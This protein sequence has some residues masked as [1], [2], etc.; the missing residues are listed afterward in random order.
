MKTKQ[1]LAILLVPAAA[2]LGGCGTGRAFQSSAEYQQ[3]GY[4]DEVKNGIDRQI[5]AEMH[6]ETPEGSVAQTYS[7]ALWERYWVNRIAYYRSNF[8]ES[9][10]Y[11]GPT[12]EQ[13]ASYIISTRHEVG[14]SELPLAKN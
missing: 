11:R 9:K 3:T 7:S 14:L 13:F 5:R 1:L 12:G 2:I 8:P 10:D 6:H 4:A